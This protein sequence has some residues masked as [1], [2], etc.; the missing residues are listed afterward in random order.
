MNEDYESRQRVIVIVEQT[1]RG[2]NSRQSERSMLQDLLYM[3]ELLMYVL[4]ASN[5]VLIIRAS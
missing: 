4:Y 1:E 3:I 5:I 2:S